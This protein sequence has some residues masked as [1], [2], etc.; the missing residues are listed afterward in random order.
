M[1]YKPETGQGNSEAVEHKTAIEP[2]SKA[3]HHKTVFQLQDHNVK[4]CCKL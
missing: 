1:E 2:S 3:T 4:T